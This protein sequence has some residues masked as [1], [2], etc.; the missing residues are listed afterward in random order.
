MAPCMNCVLAYG[1]RE[2]RGID[3]TLYTC[4]RKVGAGSLKVQSFLAKAHVFFAMD[5]SLSDK[6]WERRLANNRACRNQRLVSETA[7][8]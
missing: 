7:E 3:R 6:A 8:E 2:A 1:T 5:A 4:K